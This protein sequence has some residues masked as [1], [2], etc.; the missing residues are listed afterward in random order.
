M[1]LLWHRTRS[2]LTKRQMIQG[3]TKLF[4]AVVDWFSIPA[5]CPVSA[6]PAVNESFS[7]LPYSGSYLCRGQKGSKHQKMNC[8]SL[9]RRKTYWEGETFSYALKDG[10]KIA[11][12]HSLVGFKSISLEMYPWSSEKHSMFHLQRCLCLCWFTV[13]AASCDSLLPLG[14]ES[15]TFPV[16]LIEKQIGLIT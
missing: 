12:N 6:L 11:S 10:K 3:G 2:F 13:L 1:S 7:V 5:E 16:A 14:Q 15:S 9:G 8:H 4:T